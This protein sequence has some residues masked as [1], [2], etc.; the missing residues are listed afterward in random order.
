M[1]PLRVLYVG[2]W[3]R[4]GSTLLDLILG[5]VPGFVSVGELRYLWDRGLRDRQLCGC[6]SPV[7]E[8]PF[9]KEVLETAFGGV[10]RVDAHAMAA[11]RRRVDGL[12]R[13]PWLLAP[14]R[15]AGLEQDV[16]AY[17]EVLARIYQAVRTVSG[18]SVIVDSSKYA[19][20]GMLLAGIPGLDLRT[21]H[22]VRDSRA[23][24]YSWTR[25]KKLPEVQGEER[26]MPVF[27][28]WKSAMYWGLEN[29]GLQLLRGASTRYV[30]LRY[31]DLVDDPDAAL[32]A[33]L[34]RIEIAADLQFLHEGRLG[35]GP[36]HM[37]AGNPL[38]FERG[39]VP[40][41]PDVE[42]SRRLEAGARWT[43]TALTWPLLLRYGFRLRGR[44]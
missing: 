35:L 2:S 25:R 26:F 9:W 21:I 28:P 18:A 13:L 40:I 7:P 41:R 24:A 44:I 29:V 32:G 39:D 33:A 3:S 5:Q 17:R 12:G 8:C 11:L 38:R 20:H 42:W 14:S 15:P 1:T 16:C 27:K 23:V 6:G 22:L 19:A 34:D 4:S 30:M 37:V 36:N 31:E 43:V 10:D